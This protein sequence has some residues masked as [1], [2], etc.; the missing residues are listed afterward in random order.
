MLYSQRYALGLEFGHFLDNLSP[1]TWSTTP[2]VIIS[3]T[4]PI[5]FCNVGMGNP[6]KEDSTSHA[7]GHSLLRPQYYTRR[8]WSYPRH[9]PEFSIAQR[10][11]TR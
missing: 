5:L 4:I 6:D 3:W 7:N 1:K 2:F 11:G 9:Y 8:A 10:N